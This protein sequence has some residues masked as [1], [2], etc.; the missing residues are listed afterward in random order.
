[1]EIFELA[2]EL[3][4]KLKDDARLVRLENARKA[5]EESE[6][7]VKLS[8]EYAV[9]QQAIQNE[10]S[11]EDRD[12]AV[13]EQLQERI[14][15]LYNEITALP[16]YKEFEEAQDAVNE[17]MEAVNNTISTQISGE[18]PGGCTH[19]CATCGGCH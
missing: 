4:K 6:E 3:G 2:A 19:N 9:Q 15:A 13:I 5:Y 18:E 11:K 10:A 12:D 16:V 8:M 17:L 7:I 14:E 1:M